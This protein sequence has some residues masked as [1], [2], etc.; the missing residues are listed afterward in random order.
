MMSM[1]SIVSLIHVLSSMTL[2]ATFA[3]EGNVLLRV[4]S[5][6]RDQLHACLISF[7]RLR[8]IAIPSSPSSRIVMVS[9]GLG[10]LTLNGD[11]NWQ[12]VGVKRLGI[13][14]PKRFSTC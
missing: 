13:T 1:F 12:F 14:A 6:Q 8:W 9:S 10:S 7:E 5:A 11:P 4:R 2:F 3:L